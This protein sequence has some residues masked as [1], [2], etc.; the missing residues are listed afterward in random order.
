MKITE[1]VPTDGA[2][3][4][5]DRT[6]PNYT[7]CLGKKG[8]CKSEKRKLPKTMKEGQLADKEELTEALKGKGK[9]KSSD[10]DKKK[11]W[12]QNAVKKEGSFTAY[13]KRK[14]FKGVT[15][16]CIRMGM[17]SKDSTIQRRANLA[18]TL[19]KMH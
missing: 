1:D 18:K 7:T 9:S 15:D 4:S 19:R 2:G 10:D 14:G 11:K 16:E 17:Q 3:M 12:I 13:C 6:V 5:L 8:K